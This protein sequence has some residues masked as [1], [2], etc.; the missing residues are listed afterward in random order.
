MWEKKGK[1]QGLGTANKW[2]FDKK[3]NVI[4]FFPDSV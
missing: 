3:T 1:N 4:N 2:P